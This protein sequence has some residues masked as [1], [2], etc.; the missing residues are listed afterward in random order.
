[1]GSKSEP[2]RRRVAGWIGVPGISV[3][4]VLKLLDWLFSLGGAPG[5]AE[6]WRKAGLVMLSAMPP[7]LMQALLVGG[8]VA[9]AIYLVGVVPEL[10]GKIR[11]R[12]LRPMKALET[13]AEKCFQRTVETDAP[14]SNGGTFAPEVETK[15]PPL[16]RQ[17]INR[18]YEHL[19][20]VGVFEEDENEPTQIAGLL[21]QAA[22][23]GQ[24]LIWGSEPSFS[25]VE[26]QTPILLAI[27]RDYWRHHGIGPVSLMHD[28]SELP[29]EGCK[30]DRESPP[31]TPSLSV[32]GTFM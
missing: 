15:A 30:T 4:G 6:G 18:A 20:E 7:W 22:L 28:A 27:D 19:V 5:N 21:R 11:H 9:L 3:W 10:Y 2:L 1:M 8:G 17:P 25:P 31:G 32:I 13:G 24:I 12:T 16:D 29:D 14:K 26:W 23:D